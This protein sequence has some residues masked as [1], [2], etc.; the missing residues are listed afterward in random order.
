M[1]VAGRKRL[2]DQQWTWGHHAERVTEIHE[3]VMD[4]W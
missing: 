1:G 2:V 4:E 3:A